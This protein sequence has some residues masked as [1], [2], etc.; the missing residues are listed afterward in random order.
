MNQKIRHWTEGVQFDDN[1]REQVERTASMPFVEPWVAVMPDVHWGK[2]STVGSVIPT[3]G[4]LIPAAVGVDIGC[5][6]EAVR[7]RLTANDLD[8]GR[9]RSTYERILELV[10]VGRGQ[11]DVA[12]HLEPGILSYMPRVFDEPRW[13]EKALLQI[14][15]LGG[16]NHFI[17]ICL[18]ESDHVWVVLHSGSRGIGNAIGSYYI[19]KAQEEMA[20]YFIELPDVNLA[21][22]PECT[23]LFDDY[24][25]A[26]EWAQQY[27]SI[28]RSQILFLVANALMEEFDGPKAISWPPGDHIISCHH[29]Y[30]TR[31]NHMGKN[32]WITRKG[33]VSARK[34]QLGIIP[35]SMGDRSYI[36]RGKGNPLSFCSCSHGAGRAMGRKEAERE[37]TANEHAARLEGVVCDSSAATIDETPAAYKPI[38]AVMAAQTDL[39]EV[40]HTLKQV[41]CVKG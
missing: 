15:T 5:G 2:G 26:M 9:L 19:K 36:V 41:L 23:P 1:A 22:L 21:Y 7:T 20:K 38:D 31:E 27:A 33:A 24:V 25:S 16:G 14:G 3:Q 6:M 13:R 10:P 17:E 29:N 28:N 12:R 37:V 30:T 40:V 8:E 4:A 34:G 32:L 35:G 11:H 18:D 39:V